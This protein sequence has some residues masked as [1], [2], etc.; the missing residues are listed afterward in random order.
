[1]QH[2]V[3]LPIITNSSSSNSNNNRSFLHRFSNMATEVQQVNGGL[4][5]DTVVVDSSHVVPNINGDVVVV[6]SNGGPATGIDSSASSSIGDEPASIA[7]SS[8]A[9]PPPAAAAPQ[10][11]PVAVVL[12]T[13]DDIFPA[14]PGGLGGGGGPGPVP[15][16]GGGPSLAGI[17]AAARLGGAGSTATTT[18]SAVG[19]A[20]P[21]IRS[22]NVQKAY[23]VAPEERR[24]LNRNRFGETSELQKICS[25]IMASTGTD[26]QLTTSRDGT[27]NFLISGKEDATTNV[28]AG[29]R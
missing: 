3:Q 1:M 15:S 2:N 21:K 4:G 23:R 8:S 28:S 6:T 16:G 20:L 25:G 13:Y 19:P 24:A 10:A 7:S 5:L 11:V 17:S 18:R 22:S 27:L 29:D 14:L 26:I 12:P 9:P